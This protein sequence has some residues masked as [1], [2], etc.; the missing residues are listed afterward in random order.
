MQLLSNIYLVGG[1]HFFRTKASVADCNVYAVRTQEGIVLIDCGYDD[2]SLNT[3]FHNL[4][5][6]GMDP[7]DIQY[8]FL[9]H[10]HFDH[11]GNAKALQDRGAKIVA[12]HTVA[13]ALATG[14]E[15]TIHYAFRRSDFPVCQVDIKLDKRETIQLGGWTFEALNV[16]GHTEGSMVYLTECD[17][18]K[19]I[20]VGDFVFHERPPTTDESLAWNGGTEFNTDK[21]IDSLLRIRRIRVDVLLPGH[22]GFLMAKGSTLVDDALVIALR[23]WGNKYAERHPAGVAGGSTFDQPRASEMENLKR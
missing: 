5:Y 15:R 18:Q 23:A 20:F 19:V 21:F 6:W 17:G 3:I 16:P 2:D 4:E 10:S 22:N 8:V 7:K 13:D 1:L 12:H 14:D 9:T 11:T